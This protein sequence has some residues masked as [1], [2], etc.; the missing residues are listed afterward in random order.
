MF[1]SMAYASDLATDAPS[2]GEA[3]MLNMLLI[4]ILVAIFYVLM[5]MPQQRRFKEHRD[6][7]DGLKKGDTVLT[8]AGF[9][10]TV[11]KI[12]DDFEVVVDLGGGTKVTALR[13][14]IQSKEGDEK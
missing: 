2:A 3:F 12:K 7:L 8:A 9:I 13:S 5:I 4:I 11:D 10:G 1:V 6:M 14:T